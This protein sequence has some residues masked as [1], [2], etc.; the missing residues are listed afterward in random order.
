[1]NYRVIK[2]HEAKAPESREIESG[3]RLKFQRKST[4]FEGWLWC[5]AEDGFGGWVPEN[6]VTITQEPSSDGGGPGWC[7]LKRDYRPDELTV[8]PGDEL[9]GRMVESGWL[10]ARTADGRKGWVPLDAVERA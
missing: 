1:M 4:D 8:N 5:T 7:Y 10:W 6:W 9:D 2:P 3:Q